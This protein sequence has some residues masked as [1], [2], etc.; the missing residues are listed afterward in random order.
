MSTSHLITVF[1]MLNKK[2]S[3]QEFWL[4]TVLHQRN[5]MM[6]PDNVLIV[7]LNPGNLWPYDV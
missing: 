4:V 3:I 7:S 2:L 5:M 6:V 1:V